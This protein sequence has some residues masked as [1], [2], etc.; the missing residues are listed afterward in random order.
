MALS[1]KCYDGG[2]IA[3][4]MIII[5]DVVVVI[6]VAKKVVAQQSAGCCISKPDRVVVKIMAAP[7]SMCNAHAVARIRDGEY[8]VAEEEPDPE[9]GGCEA[10]GGPFIGHGLLVG[11]EWAKRRLDRLFLLAGTYAHGCD[12]RS[13]S[14]GAICDGFWLGV[15]EYVSVIMVAAIAVVASVVVVVSNV[16][17]AERRCCIVV[18]VVR[19]VH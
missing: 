10:D 8:A 2:I 4:V 15:P 14:R 3:G 5:V 17:A 9:T 16:D 7:N 19:C 13:C 6:V 12:C 1:L 18:W 11:R